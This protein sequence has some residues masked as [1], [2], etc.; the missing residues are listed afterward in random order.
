MTTEIRDPQLESWLDARRARLQTPAQQI[1]AEAQAEADR[2]LRQARTE[3]AKQI[4]ESRAE[5]AKL[6]KYIQR[7]RN[8]VL[9]IQQS[10]YALHVI[11]PKTRA[12]GQAR[13]QALERELV[14]HARMS[15]K[16]TT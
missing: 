8:V 3:H 5:L 6:R 16:V 10:E 11:D 15:R 12:E 9:M 14:E 4:R 1:I 2:I 13:L 7:S